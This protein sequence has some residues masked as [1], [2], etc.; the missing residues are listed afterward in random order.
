M[1]TR[2]R[3]AALQGRAS[4]RGHRIA[5]TVLR[6]WLQE[7]EQE[8]LVVETAPDDYALTEQGRRLL[9]PLAMASPDEETAAS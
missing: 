2:M 3:V 8:G 9:V 7:L 1:A 6:A 4:R 5:S